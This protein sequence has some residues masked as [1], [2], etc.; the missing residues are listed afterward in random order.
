[1]SSDS[2][3]AEMPAASLSPA[4]SITGDS[5]IAFARDISCVFSASFGS[6]VNTSRTSRP[7]AVNRSIAAN[8]TSKFFC[9]PHFVMYRS[10]LAGRPSFVVAAAFLRRAQVRDG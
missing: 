5:P 1:M 8:N 2:Y 4:F 3:R 7:S 10:A 6:S 9:T